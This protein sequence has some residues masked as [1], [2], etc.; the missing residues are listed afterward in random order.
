ML[1]IHKYG[2]LLAVFL[3]KF[4]G[5]FIFSQANTTKPV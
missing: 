2:D 3:S 4:Y 5:D 1:I